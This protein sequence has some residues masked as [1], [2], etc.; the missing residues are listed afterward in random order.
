M[1]ADEEDDDDVEMTNKN[2]NNNNKNNNNNNNSGDP[3][4]HL[5]NSNVKKEIVDVN[6]IDYNDITLDKWLEQNGYGFLK[7]TLATEMMVVELKHIKVISV[8]DLASL[9]QDL[10]KYILTSLW[11]Y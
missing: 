4:K 11:S 8:G 1:S 9:F 2:N 3:A 5:K 10:E 7:D 6:T